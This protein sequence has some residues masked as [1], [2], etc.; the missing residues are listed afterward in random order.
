M[1][2]NLT[3]SESDHMYEVKL[4]VKLEKKNNICMNIINIVYLFGS[5]DLEVKKK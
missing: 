3:Q 1:L 4:T 2:V 5:R